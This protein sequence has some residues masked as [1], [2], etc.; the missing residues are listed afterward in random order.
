MK[1]IAGPCQHESYKHSLKIAKHCAK[2]CDKYKA[3]DEYFFKASYDKANRT[4]ID[5]KRGQGLV[6]TLNDFRRMKKAIPKKKHLQMR[7][8]RNRSY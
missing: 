2:I 4:S 7:R 5:G 1:I 8:L 6:Q 3:I